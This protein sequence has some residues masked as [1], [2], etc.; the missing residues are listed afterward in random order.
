M[1]FLIDGPNLFIRQWMA[2]PNLDSEGRSIGGVV[3]FLKSVNYYA[4]K[5]KPQKI[6]VCWDGKGGSQ[7]RKELIKD[8]KQNRKP[9]VPNRNYDYELENTDKDKV[10]QRI[11]LAQYLNCLPI[12]QIIIDHIEA[13]DII[14]YICTYYLG[15][16]KVIVSSDKD[17]YQLLN[18]NTIIYNPRIKEKKYFKTLNDCFEEY[19]VYPYNFAILKA[20]AGDKSDNI[21]GIKGLGYKKIIK[22]FPFLSEKKEIE[23]EQV[24]TFCE[25]K[26]KKYLDILNSKEI[27]IRNHKAMQLKD[28]M[29][30]SHSAIKI[31]EALEK[32][33][34]L[35]TTQYRINLLKDG[36][37]D[38][39]FIESFKYLLINK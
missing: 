28:P 8:Y 25:K 38:I 27:I 26:E 24:F 18:D 11:K 36:L 21:K 29:I 15:E 23:L 1:I 6:I 17:Y 5:F 14:A 30:S 20:I 13:D 22:L 32:R 39:D 10:Y 35:N 9:L 37:N 2:K 7:R 33:L 4:Y 12:Y 31:K 34:I 3:G 16:K 19:K